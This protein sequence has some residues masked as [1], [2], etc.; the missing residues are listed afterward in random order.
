[1]KLMLFEKDSC[2]GKKHNV[3]TP[4][5][6]GR[7]LLKR[8][9]WGAVGRGIRQHYLLPVRGPFGTSSSYV[10]WYFLSIHVSH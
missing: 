9:S 8:V 10:R 7:A 3:C 1:M 2:H 4:A 5:R 6:V